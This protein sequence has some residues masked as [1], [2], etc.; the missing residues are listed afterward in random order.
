MNE[1]YYLIYESH[2]HHDGVESVEMW[3]VMSTQADSMEKVIDRLKWIE[4]REDVDLI[5]VVA[6]P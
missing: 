2:L 3:C 5:S 1:Q 6:V 4:S